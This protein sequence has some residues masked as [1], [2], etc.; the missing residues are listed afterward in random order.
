ML[1][2]L[3]SGGRGLREVAG[4][5][6]LIGRQLLAVLR[7]QLLQGLDQAGRADDGFGAQPHH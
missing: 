4:L 7:R 3:A 5:D 1:Q 2:F 6:G